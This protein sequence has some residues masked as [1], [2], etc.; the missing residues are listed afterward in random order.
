[1]QVYNT[2]EMVLF[3]DKNLIEY[4]CFVDNNSNNSRGKKLTKY[5][6]DFAW[7][8]DDFSE[9]SSFERS[10]RRGRHTRA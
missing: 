8:F 9:I 1:M 2:N 5:I 10:A 4:C 3:H 6:I 7:V